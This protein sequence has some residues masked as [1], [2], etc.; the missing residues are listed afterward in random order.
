MGSVNGG[1]CFLELRVDGDGGVLDDLFGTADPDIFF[2]FE[3]I[4]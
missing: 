2:F 4:F 3:F 1:R